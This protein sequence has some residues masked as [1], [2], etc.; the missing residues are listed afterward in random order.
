MILHICCA[1]CGG[2]CVERVKEQGKDVVLF[3]SNSNLNSRE[4][5]ERRLASVKQLAAEKQTTLSDSCLFPEYWHY[6]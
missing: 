4:E 1:P 3:Y 5:F 2:G 6:F